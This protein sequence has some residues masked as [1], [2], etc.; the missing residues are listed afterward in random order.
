MKISV[1]GKEFLTIERTPV[2]PANLSTPTYNNCIFG[3]PFPVVIRQPS[4]IS[5]KLSKEALDYL[6]TE[7]GN[8]TGFEREFIERVLRAWEEID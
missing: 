1:R 3:Q 6:A 4:G 2:Q 5:G 8:K 7:I